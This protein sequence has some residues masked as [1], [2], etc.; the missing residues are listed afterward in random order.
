MLTQGQFDV[1]VAL[2]T[3]LERSQ[4]RDDGYAL[5]WGPV[6]GATHASLVPRIA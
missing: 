4:E 2:H 5:E 1:D 3:K 6:G